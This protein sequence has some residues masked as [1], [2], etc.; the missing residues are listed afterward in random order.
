MMAHEL[1]R[2]AAQILAANHSKGADARDDAGSIVPLYAG[3]NRAAINPAAVSFSPYGAIC[4]AA[5]LNHARLTGQMWSVLFKL[6]Q[7]RVGGRVHPLR[8]LNELEDVTTDECV[9][10][11]NEAADMI[12][13]ANTEPRTARASNRATKSAK[14]RGDNRLVPGFRLAA[15]QIA[16]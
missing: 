8:D 16:P 5:S 13:P 14:E 11:L 9:A 3:D 2:Q 12:D 6:A 15:L 7:E 1:L 10:L 4:K